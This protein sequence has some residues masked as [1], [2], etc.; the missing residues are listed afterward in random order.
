MATLIEK[1]RKSIL[2]NPELNVVLKSN[3]FSDDTIRD[4]ID[5][6][7]EE[8][9]LR[10]NPQTNYSANKIPYH[11]LLP[12]VIVSLLNKVYI[13][14]QRNS[15]QFRDGGTSFDL[16]GQRAAQALQALQKYE[17]EF[18]KKV[19]HYKARIAASYYSGPI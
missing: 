17:V 10:Y 4:S 5:Y 15:I 8:I 1:I 12:G 3:E 6:A 2:D 13:H 16:F 9:N 11:I 18:D 19:R 7:V 14:G